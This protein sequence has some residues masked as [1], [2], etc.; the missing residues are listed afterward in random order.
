[1]YFLIKGTPNGFMLR[2]VRVGFINL[3]DM[4]FQVEAYGFIKNAVVWEL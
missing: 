3:R 2:R 1:M 4:F